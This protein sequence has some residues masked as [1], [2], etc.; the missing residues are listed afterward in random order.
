MI[1]AQIEGGIVVNAIEVDPGNIPEWAATFPEL[2]GG[3]GIGWSYA[4]GAFAPPEDEADPEQD[5]EALPPITRRQLRLTLVRSGIS[6]ESVEAM[7]EA[8]PDGLEKSEALIEWEDAATFERMHPTLIQIG[9]SLGLTPEQVD[10]L[11]R[12]ALTT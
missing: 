11:W 2:S 5:R 8:M 3:A 7:I 9:A 6:L 12:Q 10:D 1:L 4:D